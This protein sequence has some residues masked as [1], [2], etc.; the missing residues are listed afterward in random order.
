MEATAL[1][2]GLE[3]ATELLYSGHDRHG[4]RIAQH[5]DCLSSHL[6]CDIEQSVKI[7]HGSLPVAN[8]LHDFGRPRRSLA[9]LGALGAALVSE[10]PRDPR[11]H[12]DHRLRVVDHDH[13]ARAEHGALGDK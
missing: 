1:N 13:S 12:R 3:L 9:A 4:A 11:Y 5:A 8:P 7:F 2:K 10:E 6:L